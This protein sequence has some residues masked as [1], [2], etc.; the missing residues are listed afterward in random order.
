M[1]KLKEEINS[2]EKTRLFTNFKTLTKTEN[3]NSRINSDKLNIKNNNRILSTVSYGNDPNFQEYMLHL[4][5][6]RKKEKEECL[7][8]IRQK[9]KKD[10]LLSKLDINKKISFSDFYERFK[11][12]NFIINYFDYYEIQKINK[13]KTAELIQKI[14]QKLRGKKQSLKIKYESNEQ[15]HSN[16]SYHSYNNSENNDEIKSNSESFKNFKRRISLINSN[17]YRN[18]LNLKKINIKNFINDI[19]NNKNSIYID[20]IDF[21]LIKALYSD[22]EENDKKIND[23]LLINEIRKE[24]K[25]YMHKN[26]NRKNQYKNNY[27]PDKYSIA[28]SLDKKSKTK[29]KR[30]KL[31]IDK[32]LE[33]DRPKTTKTLSTYDF[34]YLNYIPNTS[35]YKHISYHKNLIFNNEFINTKKGKKNKFNKKN[36][37]NNI[38][39]ESNIYSERNLLIKSNKLINNLSQI[40][41]VLKKDKN[42]T[43][44]TILRANTAFKR[45]Y[46]I[47]SD[48]R[49][50][51][52]LMK[53]NKKTIG[54]IKQ[55]KEKYLKKEKINIFRELKEMT[56]STDKNS[57]ESTEVFTKTLNTLCKEEKKFNKNYKNFIKNNYYLKLE[58][59]QENNIENTKAKDN[60]HN[61]I[62]SY[63]NLKLNIKK[64]CK[65]INNIIKK[66]K[67]SKI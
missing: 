11:V 10:P 35:Q 31:L 18:S 65:E 62:L 16:H 42:Y 34:Q 39:T 38:K 25:L 32:K 30:L 2:K 6:L 36:K 20:G 64:R 66:S 3:I 1:K 15:N 46:R 19:N 57:I 51:E 21:N 24:K 40:K 63:E 37:Y 41:S 47:K 17:N 33:K 26:I 45:N 7:E 28:H 43:S 60:I 8:Y 5:N 4:D 48:Q 67:K 58:E 14:K 9:N 13:K 49:L 52:S 55:I 50:M 61:Y 44:K 27:T 54:K 56:K 12:N 59:L 23:L 29:L 53:D 22:I